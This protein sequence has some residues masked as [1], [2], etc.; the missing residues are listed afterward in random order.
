MTDG[1]GRAPYKTPDATDCGRCDRDPTEELPVAAGRFAEQ[2]PDVW[3]PYAD[4]GEAC[5][6]AGPIDD[7]SKRLVKLGT[8][9]AA[10]P[11]THTFGGGS[12]KVTISRRSSRSPFSRFRRSASPRR[13]RD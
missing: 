12:R 6:D 5:A 13:S 8:A 11:S 9:V 7:E 2:Y 4:L 10:Q 1:S 3:V